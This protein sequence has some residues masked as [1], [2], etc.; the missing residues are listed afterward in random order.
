MANY[1]PALVVLDVGWPCVLADSV[2]K[3][4]SDFYYKFQ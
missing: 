2:P 1:F 4:V 3:Y